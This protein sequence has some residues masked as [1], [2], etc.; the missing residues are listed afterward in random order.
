MKNFEN[1]DLHKYDKIPIPDSVREIRKE[2]IRLKE[3]D[4]DMFLSPIEHQLILDRIVAC[5]EKIKVVTSANI[6]VTPVLGTYTIRETKGNAKR[7]HYS[8]NETKMML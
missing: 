2:I 1:V 7:P 6:K 4:N 3:E 5:E 8:I